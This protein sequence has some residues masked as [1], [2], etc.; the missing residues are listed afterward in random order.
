MSGY[1]QFTENLQPATTNCV[2][3]PSFYRISAPSTREI[4]RSNPVRLDFRSEGAALREQ[5]LADVDVGSRSP[6]G[7]DSVYSTE[8][9]FLYEEELNRTRRYGRS[10][11]VDTIR[12]VY[13]SARPDTPTRSLAE[14]A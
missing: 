9:G 8:L 13:R 12:P 7:Y 11:L 6:L 10:S 4:P 3:V 5:I 1:R 14:I 2:P